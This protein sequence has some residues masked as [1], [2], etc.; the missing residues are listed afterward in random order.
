[1]LMETKDMADMYFKMEM[2]MKY[3]LPTLLVVSITVTAITI[4]VARFLWLRHKENLLRKHGYEWCV[5]V[6]TY[7]VD[8]WKCK[9]T[10]DYLSDT[11]VDRTGYWQLKKRIEYEEK[12]RVRTNEKDSV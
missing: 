6:S 5:S 2:W 4:A 12:K 11:T 9:E 10:G 7:D 8:G 1:M 3:I